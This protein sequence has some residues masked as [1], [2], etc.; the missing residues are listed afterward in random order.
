MGAIMCMGVATANSILVVSF[1]RERLRQ[2]GDAVQAAIEAGFTRFRPV[3]MT[4]LAMIIGMI[5]M[6]LG[7]GEGGEQNAPLGRAVIGGLIWRRSR[8]WSSCRA[9]FSLLHHR[10]RRRRRRGDVPTRRRSTAM[11]PEGERPT[12]RDDATAAARARRPSIAV[13]I[14]RA[15]DRGR[16]ARRRHLS[17]HPRPRRR[18]D[19]AG[20]VT[21]EAAVPTVDVVHPEG[22]PPDQEIVLPGNVQ[23]FQDTP[24]YA[25]TSGYLRHWY[26]D[27]GAHVKQRRPAGRDRDAGGRR[28]AAPGARGSRDG[29]SQPRPGGEHL[30]AR[31]DA[32]QDKLGLRPGA[33]QHVRRLSTRTRRSSTSKQA[34]VIAARAAAILR[35]GLC[36]LRRHHHRAQHR[37]RR[38]HRRRRRHARRASFSTCRRSTRSASSPPCPRSIRARSIPAPRRT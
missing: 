14:D 9:V 20:H 31:S 34:D 21:E 15:R 2:H 22:P 3:L 19:G 37:Y 10:A 26:F 35:K 12:G 13:G 4:A 27:I 8:R 32:V 17:R 24:I 30:E 28:A 11:T 38:A 29:A 1:A 33:R 36:A 7:L 16:R 25:R 6:A 23:A 5:P 18:R